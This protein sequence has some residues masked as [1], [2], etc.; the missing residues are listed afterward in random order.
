MLEIK[1]PP[2]NK[3]PNA[4][5]KMMDNSEKHHILEDLLRNKTLNNVHGQPEA[6][7]ANDGAG[8][9]SSDMLEAVD[10]NH[11]AGDAPSDADTVEYNHEDVP[12]DA[13][14]V[15]YNHEDVPSTAATVEVN[16]E[17]VFSAAE[18]VAHDGED[19]ASDADTVEYESEVPFAT[20]TVE[21][22]GKDA[23]LSYPT[24]P[25]LP[26]AYSHPEG[27]P[28]DKSK[29]LNA[30]MVHRP[31]GPG[32]VN[33]D[34]TCFM[35]SVLASLTYT[36]AL[37]QYLLATNHYD[38]CS[39]KGFCALCA[40]QKHVHR[41]FRDP[42]SYQPGAAFYPKEFAENLTSINSQL[43]LGRQEDA[44][45]FYMH[46]LSSIQKASVHGLGKLPPHIVNTDFIYQVF[47]GKLQS[48]VKCCSCQ[49]TSNTYQDY[50][51]LSV[52]LNFSL[53]LRQTLAD[54]IRPEVLGEDPLNRY[55]C[56]SCN[57]ETQAEKRM[58]ISELPL[59]L[60]VHLKRFAYD[61]KRQ[62]MIKL[63]Q[64]IGFD[65]VLDMAP[66]VCKEK[67][68]EE[69]KYEL[70]AVLVHS[71][72]RCDYGHYYT[73]VKSSNDDGW[74]CMDD[75]IVRP[76]S[77]EEMKTSKAYMLF[78]RQHTLVPSAEPPVAD[79][80]SLPHG[81]KRSVDTLLEDEQEE[82]TSNKKQK[83]ASA[84]ASS[85]KTTMRP[86]SPPQGKKRPLDDQPEDDQE[87]PTVPSLKRLKTNVG[88]LLPPDQEDPAPP[89]GL[90]SL[91]RQMCQVGS[92]FATSP[93]VPASLPNNAGSPSGPLI[94]VL[95]KYDVPVRKFKKTIPSKSCLKRTT[96]P[97]DGA[98]TEQKQDRHVQF[99]PV[100][101]YQDFSDCNWIINRPE[102]LEESDS[103]TPED[104]GWIEGPQGWMPIDQVLIT[105]VNKAVQT[106]LVE[107]RQNRCKRL[108]RIERTCRARV[109]RRRK[110]FER[111]EKTHRDRGQTR[112][113]RM[114]KR[115]TGWIEKSIEDY[116]PPKD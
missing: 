84:G 93:E 66:Y 103:L 88:P 108:K 25:P 49:G 105:C 94:P 85:G 45:E 2:T 78:Y 111:I 33:G 8:D 43:T 4:L 96:S 56:P 79:P 46:L 48:Q 99:N 35:N 22:D 75:D 26:N 13:D 23:P 28:F 17:D 1:K 95:P 110:R 44:H 7:E 90:P 42:M 107:K 32:L 24:G 37:T 92:L 27:P 102:D 116:E 30:W 63:N 47:G 31:I 57:Q 106:D 14:T 113:R 80:A 64:R 87:P 61:L 16:H 98:D 70:Y 83:Q 34:N 68:I 89:K 53:H 40:L 76:A 86:P 60:T 52:D 55:K 82:V 67:K 73:Y 91:K 3:E 54:F 77:Q 72:P 71:G 36:P 100:I 74:Y 59:M 50:L 6:E 62:K 18:T 104:L 11:D 41:C 19:A 114:E 51:D 9:L 39:A 101:D 69:A 15:E 65:E 115:N 38:T 12:S 58:T 5:T 97:K 20:D 10:A 21:H 112:R 109:E 81:K 29:L